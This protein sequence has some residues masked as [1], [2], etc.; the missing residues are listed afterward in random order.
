M[1]GWEEGALST[2]YS[3]NPEAASRPFDEKREGFVIGE[4]AGILAIEV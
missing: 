3:S 2:S 4:G 1:V